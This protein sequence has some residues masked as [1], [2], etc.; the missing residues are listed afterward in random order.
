MTCKVA[1]LISGNG[2]NLQAL[3]DASRDMA[4]PAHISLVLSN[5]ADAYGLQRAKK[6]G[7]P[8]VVLSHRDYDSRKAFDE[9]MHEVL[10]EHGIEFVCLAGFMRL[11]SAEF[12]E[13]WK[14]RMINIHPSLLPDYKGLKTHERVLADGVSHTGCTVHYVIPAMDEGDVI[15][16]ENVAVQL[17]DTA[18]LLQQRVHAAEHHV[19]PKALKLAIEALHNIE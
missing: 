9:A 17:G 14:G 2:S 10:T 4:Y 3:L 19:Y 16:Q 15:M 13:Q 12:V 7:V 6:A 18:E 1:V 8:Y 11:L 5:K